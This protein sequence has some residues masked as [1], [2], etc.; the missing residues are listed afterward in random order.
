MLAGSLVYSTLGLINQITDPYAF[1][2][3]IRNK[4][5]TNDRVFA[6]IKLSQYN[7]A[8]LKY[9]SIYNMAIIIILGLSNNKYSKTKIGYQ[10][11]Y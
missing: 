6:L 8:G 1:I 11:C 3:W 5:W 10:P 9:S 7:K 4:A 2:A